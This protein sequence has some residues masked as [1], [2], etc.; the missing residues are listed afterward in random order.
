MLALYS[1]NLSVI[2]REI[3]FYKSSYYMISFVLI[4]L[5]VCCGLGDDRLV[6]PPGYLNTYLSDVLA[7]YLNTSSVLRR[8]HYIFMHSINGENN[9]DLVTLW[10]NGG[11]GCASKL[12]FI[13]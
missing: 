7:G 2:S 10:M 3:N 11:P 12:G 6:V 9:T 13:Q 4:G 1:D 5:L 8:L